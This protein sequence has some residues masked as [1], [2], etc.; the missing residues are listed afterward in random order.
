MFAD[1]D[2]RMQACK[3]GPWDSQMDGWFVSFDVDWFLF[4]EGVSR[5]VHPLPHKLLELHDG[6]GGGLIGTTWSVWWY[7]Q[8]GGNG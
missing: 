7:G 3:C 6:G 5:L 4:V 8:H 1:P 2:A